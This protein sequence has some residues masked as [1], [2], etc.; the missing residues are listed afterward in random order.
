MNFGS[1]PRK[2]SMQELESHWT[3]SRLDKAVMAKLGMPWADAHKYIRQRD[4]FVAKGGKEQVPEGERYVTRQTNYKVQFG[5]ILC[6]SD[7]LLASMK[8]KGRE[9]KNKEEPVRFSK[10]KSKQMA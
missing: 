10:D 6:I 3:D 2:F 7:Y 9:L 1:M 5:D 8:A 4:I